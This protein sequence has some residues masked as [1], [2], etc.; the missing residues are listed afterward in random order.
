MPSTLETTPAAICS[1]QQSFIRNIV[2]GRNLNPNRLS[3]AF[4]IK[5]SLLNISLLFLICSRHDLVELWRVEYSGGYGGMKFA[6]CWVVP[7]DEVGEGT[8]ARLVLL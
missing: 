4:G 6:F 8:L 5:Y 3:K 1:R 7:S 2:Q